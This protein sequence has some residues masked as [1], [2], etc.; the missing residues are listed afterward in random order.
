MHIPDGFLDGRTMAG[1]AAA[2]GAGVAVALR[3]LSGPDAARRAPLLGLTGAFLF[4]AQM[5]NFPVAAGTSGHLLGGA[6]AA[7]LLGPAAAVLVLTSVVVLQCFLFHDGGVLSLGANLFNIAIVG[8]VVG[9]GVYRLV[10]RG[11]GTTRL[12]LGAAFAAWCSVVVAATACAGEL[13]LSGTVSARLALPAMTGIHLLIGLF[14][15]V[16]TAM[17]IAA[18]ARIR[19]ELLRDDVAIPPGRS[20]VLLGV[21]SIAGLAAVLAPFASGLPDGLEWVA[22]RFSFAH[23]AAE[24]AGAAPVDSLGSSVGGTLLAAALGTVIAFALSWLV[25]RALARRHPDAPQ[26]NAR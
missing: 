22:E 20:F 1:T 13:A 8:P 12:L 25:A 23:R 26:G 15:A 4:A 17:T 24:P 14:E 9:W 7:V 3:A 6:L 16:I 2:A 10:A 19:P 21:V 5:L 11:G 18:I